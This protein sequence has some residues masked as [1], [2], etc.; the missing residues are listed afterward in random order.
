MFDPLTLNVKLL[1][2]LTLDAAGVT[3]YDAAGVWLVSF[4]VTELLVILLPLICSLYY[5][6]YLYTHK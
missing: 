3:L 4:I 2:S 6:N 5:Q 1:P